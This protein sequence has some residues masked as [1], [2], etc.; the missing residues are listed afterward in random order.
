MRFE[1]KF[2]GYSKP[3]EIKSKRYLW[4]LFN[5]FAGT[6]CAHDVVLSLRLSCFGIYADEYGSQQPVPTRKS[7]SRSHRSKN[8]AATTTDSI[9]AG[10]SSYSFK[11][12]SAFWPARIAENVFLLRIFPSCDRELSPMTLTFKLR[13]RMNQHYKHI[14]ISGQFS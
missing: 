13:V 3:I 14:V 6:V 7:H 9:R 1:F 5:C 12:R 4:Q 11:F 10:V 2:F 8:S